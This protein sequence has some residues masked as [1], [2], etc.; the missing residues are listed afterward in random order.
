MLKIAIGLTFIFTALCAQNLRTLQEAGVD[1]IVDEKPVRI[2]R[3]IPRECVGLGPNI[4]TVWGGEYANTSLS[5]ACKKS[6]ATT[7][8][9]IQPMSIHPKIQTVGELEVLDFIKNK[10]A[11]EP[12]N[13][14]LIDSRCADWFETGSI[15]GAVNLP[16]YEILFDPDFEEDYERMLRLTRVSKQGDV[17]SFENAK[18]LLLFCNGSWCGQSTITIGNLM[19]IGYPPEKLL[20]FRGGMQDWRLH[21]FT[22]TSPL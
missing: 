20:W 12:E 5:P 22:T 1:V 3:E 17:Y 14:V 18:T 13:Y 9:K 10:L 7:V 4:S 8:G 11:L 19:E 2:V 15:P 6:F 16:Y 21:N